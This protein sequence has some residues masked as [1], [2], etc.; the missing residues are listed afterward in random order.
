MNHKAIEQNAKAPKRSHDMLAMLLAKENLTIR[1]GKYQTAAFDIDNRTLYMPAFKDGSDCVY[2]LLV[3]HEIG[4]ALYTPKTLFHGAAK[5]IPDV[6][7]S[8]LNIIEDVRIENKIK[9]KYPGLRY[10]FDK[11]YEEIAKMDFF[12]FTKMK[13]MGIKISQCPFIDRLNLNAKLG[14]EMHFRNATE[15]TLWQEAMNVD[16]P[17]DVIRVAKKIYD[18]EKQIANLMPQMNMS[19][20]EK[21]GKGA[22]AEEEYDALPGQGQ[23]QKQ[24]K[25]KKKEKKSSDE[26]DDSEKDSAKKSKGTKEEEEDGDESGNGEKGDSDEESDTK[27]ENSNDKDEGS[28]DEKGKGSSLSKEADLSN[29]KNSNLSNDEESD[30]DRK[31]QNSSGQKG[32]DGPAN[33]FK[34]EESLTD[35]AFRSREH[36]LVDKSSAQNVY[37]W[38]DES[39]AESTIVKFSDY[40]K[41]NNEGM[42]NIV[43]QEYRKFKNDVKPY[44]AK[45][46]QEF[47]MRK[48]AT[49]FLNAKH[50]ETG[51]INVDKLHRYRT[52]EDIFSKKTKFPKGKN[53][54][55][56]FIIDYSSSMSD[57]ISSVL[58]KTLLLI[59]FCK[60]R[61]IPYAIYGFTTEENYGNSP[62]N[63]TKF[64][65]LNAQ[66]LKIFELSRHDMSSRER[67]L[68]EYDMFVQMVRFSP[69]LGKT[70]LVTSAFATFGTRPLGGTPLF[71]A[72]LVMR[73]LC[74][75]LRQKWKVD[76]FHL[77]TLSDGDGERAIS[78]DGVGSGIGYNGTLDILMSKTGRRKKFDLMDGFAEQI[79]DFSTSNIGTLGFYLINEKQ[80]VEQMARSKAGAK[81]LKPQELKNAKQT[82]K[83]HKYASFDHF[84]GYSRYLYIIPDHTT[85]NLE[86]A[87]ASDISAHIKNRRNSQNLMVEIAKTIS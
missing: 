46:V 80:P 67:E 11:G 42:A 47:E 48:S 81:G 58:Y 12:G 14:T 19:L 18:Y 5:N 73:S 75:Q 63:W 79:H 76:K 3:S 64:T 56:C 51:I 83:D 43:A 1:H 40:F 39:Y 41:S 54:G 33:K 52:S 70:Y 61:N 27:S 69:D 45:L 86:N 82:M 29:D 74:D 32:T 6:P 38:I 15:K 84:G 53:H 77:C 66:N 22:E 49:R 25:K 28:S 44:V 87:A 16:T 59:Q 71:P 21:K 78:A 50:A 8:F 62:K 13:A 35:S 20:S 37:A 34:P 4:H 2:D 68:S 55:L 30:D 60:Q 57:T 85:V 24:D 10:T 31:K 26:N 9:G 23:Q 65:N 17:D 36:E 72:I 7:W